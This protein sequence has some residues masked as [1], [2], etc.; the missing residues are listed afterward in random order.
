M[1]RPKEFDRDQVLDLAVEVFWRRGYEATS[2]NELVDALGIGR[3]SLYDT[4]G[5][6][7]SLFLAALDRYRQRHAGDVL[8][9]LELEIPLRRAL[10]QLLDSLIG[11]LLCDG[12]G[13]TCMMVAAVTERC[14]RDAEVAER[15][16]SN[17]TGMHDAFER[18][19]ARAQREGELGKHHD[20]RALA[21]YFVNTLNG[22]QITGKAL[23]DRKALLEIADVALA[24]LG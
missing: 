10:R 7:H 8:K 14:P 9:V 16:A 12:E 6:K 13:K 3:Q 5:D 11:Q 20:P 21:R 1:A 18:R 24:I 23:R 22:L 19:F 4:F 17:L 15:F 2:M